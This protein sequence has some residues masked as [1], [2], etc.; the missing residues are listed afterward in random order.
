MDS[1]RELVFLFSQK[2]SVQPR[3]AQFFFQEEHV[4]IITMECR[5]R[6]KMMFQQVT[7]VLLLV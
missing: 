4:I 6:N 2:L 1:S 3:L 5:V 7:C